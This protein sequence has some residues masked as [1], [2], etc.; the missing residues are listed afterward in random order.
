MY[1]NYVCTY[2]IYILH[3]VGRVTEK[4]SL[5]ILLT[6]GDRVAENSLWVATIYGIKKPEKGRYQ[7]CQDSGCRSLDALN[8]LN[9]EQP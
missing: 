6:E 4:G 2:F 1:F 5:T 9:P 8:G 3:G 7:P